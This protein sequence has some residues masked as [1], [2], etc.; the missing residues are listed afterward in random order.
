[1]EYLGFGNVDTMCGT[2]PGIVALGYRH[3][4]ICTNFGHVQRFMEN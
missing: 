1:M 2:E 3:S 4:D